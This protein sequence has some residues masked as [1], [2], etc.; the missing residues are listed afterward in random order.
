[1]QIVYHLGAHCTDE[2]R[3]LKCLLKNKG[4]LAAEGI[5]VSGPGRYRN[6]FRD[7]LIKLRGAR[8]PKAVQQLILDAVLELETPRRVIFSHE[9]FL[10]LP[11]RVLGEGR[12]Y[13]KAGE[14]VVWLRNVFP[15]NPVEFHIAIRNPA[16]F[17]PA[18][19]A[20]TQEPDFR[21]FAAEVDARTVAW[22]DT[23][24][25]MRAG[26]PD[27]PVTVWCNEDTALL[28]PEVLRAVAGHSP[29]LRL[30]GTDDF[31]ASLMTAEGMTRMQAYLASHPPVT[32]AQRRRVV[33]AFLDKFAIPEAVEVELDLPGWTVEL[34]EEATAAYEADMARL[35]AI[36]GVTF[37]CP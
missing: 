23:I 31:L 7:T 20:T 4:A 34:V 26:A 25:R 10:C 36:P 13:P 32:D 27:C 3:I 18:L 15:D 11:T 2:D 29:G 5:A 16:T 17:I 24:A 33:A 22:S 37:L 21:A 6:L 9:Q 28:W 12:L 35:A 1:M 30:A 19:Y 14:K 8:A